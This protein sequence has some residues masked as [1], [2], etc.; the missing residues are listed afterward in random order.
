MVPNVAGAP[1]ILSAEG[2]T[3][4]NLYV[5][6]MVELAIVV[7]VVSVGA[8]GFMALASKFMVPATEVEPVRAA[9][10]PAAS[11]LGFDPQAA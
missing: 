11:D 1:G 10:A 2:W 9:A 8:L 6:T 7:G 5:P 3:T 4:M